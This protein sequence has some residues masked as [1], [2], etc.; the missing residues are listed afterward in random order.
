MPARAPGR[1][2]ALLRIFL[3]ICASSCRR[4]RVENVCSCMSRSRRVW[5]PRRSFSVFTTAAGAVMPLLKSWTNHHCSRES[6]AT[7]RLRRTAAQ[8]RLLRA[9]DL[10]RPAA[11]SRERTHPVPHER[12]ALAA[13]RISPRH[14]RRP[15]P[16]SRGL[17]FTVAR[18]MRCRSMRANR[19][20]SRSSTPIGRRPTSTDP[21]M[22]PIQSGST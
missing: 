13:R 8:P 20:A 22:G 14:R 9:G 21:A 6:S 17:I 10:S 12:G 19:C 5:A 3:L 16:W 15:P 7:C 11:A 4:F 1:L 18:S 2:F